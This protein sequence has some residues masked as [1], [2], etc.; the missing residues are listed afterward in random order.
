MWQIDGSTGG[1]ERP[2]GTREHRGAGSVCSRDPS[3]PR[4]RPG[5]ASLGAPWPALAPQARARADRCS[6]PPHPTVWP[7]G[8]GEPLGPSPVCKPGT[9]TAAPR[10][11]LRTRRGGAGPGLAR[12]APFPPLWGGVRAGHRGRH[13]RGRALPQPRAQGGWREGH[14]DPPCER[15][16]SRGVGPRPLDTRQG[17]ERAKLGASGADTAA[18]GHPASPRLPRYPTPP[19][20]GDT[21]RVW[22]R[23]GD[24]A[25]LS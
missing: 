25:S 20:R 19:H 5:D 21:T 1:G 22:G 9:G 16:E 23:R 15:A 12:P 10:G 14:G 4:G 6:R 7:C 13:G 11:T 18:G 2:L 17:P 3:P 8:L 24:W